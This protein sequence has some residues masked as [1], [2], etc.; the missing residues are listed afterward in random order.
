MSDRRGYVIPAQK[1]TMALPKGHWFGKYGTA[2][3][4]AH[5]DQNPSLSIQDGEHE[6]IVRCHAG[7]DWRD[8]K[9]ELR[10]QG[11]LKEWRGPNG[12]DDNS[13]PI[14]A[15]LRSTDTRMANGKKA[16]VMRNVFPI[17]Y[18]S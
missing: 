16:W 12:Q 18:Q 10:R 1:L 14:K 9:T 3:C 15:R 7:C 4:P 17:A 5:D 11:L 8:I 13:K 6:I 2:C